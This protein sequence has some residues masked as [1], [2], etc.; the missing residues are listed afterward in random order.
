[1]CSVPER[2]GSEVQIIDEEQKIVYF[3]SIQTGYKYD[4]LVDMN[5]CTIKSLPKMEGFYPRSTGGVSNVS[6]RQVIHGLGAI[7]DLKTGQTIVRT[8]Q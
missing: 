1:M 2:G 4:A 3:Q 6:G 5:S 8:C 7:W